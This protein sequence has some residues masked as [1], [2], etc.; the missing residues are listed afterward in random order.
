MKLKSFA[1]PQKIEA[2][3]MLLEGVSAKEIAAKFGVHVTTIYGL[4][5]E[6][7][8]GH[9]KADR[10]SHV[11]TLRLSDDEFRA[12]NA[13]VIEAGLPTRTAALRSLIRS[14]TGFLELRRDE[15]Q[16]LTEAK[17]ELKAQGRNLNQLTYALNKAALKGNAKLTNPDREFLAGVK[18]AYAALDARL[19]KTFREVR[20]KGRDAL[21]V[22][23]TP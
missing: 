22:G 19:A 14:A 6:R 9:T 16:D 17:T 18:S 2:A 7:G 21:H 1:T 3:N 8:H 4:R 5:K 12:L 23:K 13:F 11:V 20:Q 10:A 15:M